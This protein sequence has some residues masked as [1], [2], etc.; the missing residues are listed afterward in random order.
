MS[1]LIAISAAANAYFDVMTLTTY[2]P[3][4]EKK[5]SGRIFSFGG[6]SNSTSNAAAASYVVLIVLW[7]VLY[8]A[9]IVA[10]HR[11]LRTS[12]YAQ[13]RPMHLAFRLFVI[14]SFVVVFYVAINRGLR[15]FFAC[16]IL[17]FDPLSTSL[18]YFTYLNLTAFIYLP[19]NSVQVRGTDSARLGVVNLVSSLKAQSNRFCLQ[20]NLFAAV[21]SDAAYAKVIKEADPADL[22][23]PQFHDVVIIY[24]TFLYNNVQGGYIAVCRR[25]NLIVVAFRGTQ[26][27]E[28]KKTDLM[29]IL[30]PSQL[31]LTSQVLLHDVPLQKH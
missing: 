17:D 5:R 7:L 18:L 16:S 25:I 4:A 1:I 14:L 15:F 2:P 31:A 20:L 24:K 29:V 9:M 23:S 30:C 3:K 11:S 28:D 21:M 10:T 22:F 27:D 12:F 13:T 6:V 19:Y 8:L 26:T